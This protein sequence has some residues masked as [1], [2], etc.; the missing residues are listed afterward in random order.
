MII[1]ARV[2]APLAMDVPVRI[3]EKPMFS[4]TNIVVVAII[5]WV[6]YAASARTIEIRVRSNEKIQAF[7]TR[8]FILLKRLIGDRGNPRYTDPIRELAT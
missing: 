1:L 4:R 2:D 7:S 8:R 3:E 6:E 5:R